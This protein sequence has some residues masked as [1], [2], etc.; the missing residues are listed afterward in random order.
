M[1]NY[2]IILP[3]TPTNIVGVYNFIQTNK[4]NLTNIG[5]NNKT[6][7]IIHNPENPLEAS[8]RFELAEDVF[9]ILE[10]ELL[11][12]SAIICDSAEEYLLKYPIKNSNDIQNL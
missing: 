2:Y 3:I 6:L 7:Q 8:Y 9:L 1:K 4:D 12:L 10:S 11:D 5:G